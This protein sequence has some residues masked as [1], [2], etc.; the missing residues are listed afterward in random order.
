MNGSI[1]NHRNYSHPYP[2]PFR[3]SLRSSQN[4]E[5]LQELYQEAGELDDEPSDELRTLALGTKTV[6][7]RTS[8]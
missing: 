8:V 3:D 2:N 1:G 6:L 7:A 5:K 4:I